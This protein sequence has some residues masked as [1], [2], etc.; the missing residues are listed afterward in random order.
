MLVCFHVF[1]LRIVWNISCCFSFPSYFISLLKVI[2]FDKT[3]SPTPYSLFLLEK[4]IFAQLL[5]IFLSFRRK[6]L[7]WS[8]LIHSTPSHASYLRSILRLF[9]HLRLN[10][11]SGLFPSYFPINISRL[12]HACTNSIP[13]RNH[14]ELKIYVKNKKIVS[15]KVRKETLLKF[16]KVM[17]IRSL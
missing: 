9:S 2:R 4:L 1:A 8:S 3:D 5:K 6:A 7:S 13:V 15:C 11:P 10:L 14:T 12:P 16:W 17:A